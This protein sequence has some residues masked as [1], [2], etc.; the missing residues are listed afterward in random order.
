MRNLRFWRLLRL[1]AARTP[2]LVRNRRRAADV[3]DYANLEARQLLSANCPPTIVDVTYDGG[4]SSSP[5]QWQ[6]VEI[7]FSENVA[8]DASS[9]RLFNDTH[10]GVPVDLQGTQFN[11]DSETFIASWD[12]TNLAQPLGPANYSF[13]IPS[14]QVSD[15]DDGFNLDGNGDEVA[16]DA[17]GGKQ[18]VAY[19]GDSNLDGTVDV[20]G[21]GF[22]FVT[23]LGN[24][25]DKTWQQADFNDDGVVDILGD[26]FLLVGNLGQSANLPAN[27]VDGSINLPSRET[28]DLLSHRDDVPGAL[29]V[30][31]LKFLITEVNS[32][33]PRLHF[34]NTNNVPFHY[35]F[36]RD[37]LGYSQSAS[38]FNSQTYFTNLGRVNLAGTLIA[39]ESYVGESGQQGLIT[40][41]FWP[42]DPVAFRFVNQAW[43]SISAAAPWLDGQFAFHPVSETQWESVQL[44]E[45]Q[46]D[47]SEIELIH[48]D[49]LFGQVAYQPMNQ[50]ESFG[51]LVLADSSTALTARDIPIFNSLPNDL[52]TVA[53]II[54]EVQQTPLSHVNLKAR[55]NNLPNAFIRDASTDPQIV[56]FLNQLVKFTVGPDGFELRLATQLEVDQHFESLRPSEP[57]FPARDLSET[58]IQALQNIGFSDADAF[59][60]KAANVAELQ[61]IMPNVAP[62]GFAIPFYFY[63]EYM[64]FNGFYAE[65]ETMMADPQF[66]SDT[67][68]RASELDEFRRR[69]RND[70]T[71]PA[72]MF[73]ALT[74]L[75]GSFAAEITPRLRSS[76]NAE[77]LEGFSGAGLYDSYT[78][79]A[80]EGHISKSVKQVWASLWTFR[81]FEE[82]EF[83]RVDHMQAAMGVLV[84]PNYSDEIANGVA[85]TKNIFDPNWEGYYI[86]VQVGE[87]LITNPNAESIPEEILVASLLG[88]NQYETQY[89]RSSNQVEPGE[90]VLTQTEILELV[91]R[92]DQINQHF[93]SLYGTVPGDRDF[94]MEIEFKIT[95]DGDLAIKQ[96]RPW[97]G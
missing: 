46:F 94:I 91:G 73:D 84:H 3:C 66:Q 6:S 65:V 86:N 50:S 43:E 34:L 33:F 49:D 47:A 71:M 37:V 27:L 32:D 60:S 14:N 54:T 97:V 22:Q 77:D 63:D 24:P 69:I 19:P 30:R 81:G 70:G 59:G 20:L 64:E 76:A 18:Y 8:V 88:Q 2:R 16:G 48:S 39:H 10:A 29:N 42:T 57:Q 58:Q 68:F 12:F 1:K 74:T 17:F 80:D 51:R 87:D 96:A 56:P 53:G 52:A 67:S 89:I 26:G 11:Y 92:M 85:V 90:R 23:S 55:Q 93:A 82:R 40:L 35:S 75:Q 28:F 41:E 31:E 9:L 83:Y 78:H 38:Q 61:H 5:D 79:H 7:H 62:D 15:V 36:Y 25:G 21:D 4:E 72:W 13:L 95:A 44:E 45:F